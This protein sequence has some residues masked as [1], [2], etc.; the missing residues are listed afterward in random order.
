MEGAHSISIQFTPTGSSQALNCLPLQNFTISSPS[1]LFDGMPNAYVEI[2]L[3]C[4]CLVIQLQHEF[5]MCPMNFV[6][7]LGIIFNSHICQWL[8]VITAEYMVNTYLMLLPILYWSLWIVNYKP[9]SKFLNDISFKLSYH[10]FNNFSVTG[11]SFAVEATYNG[12]N[13]ILAIDSPSEG[14]FCCQLDI[15]TC[16]NCESSNSTLLALFV[17]IIKA[18]EVHYY[19]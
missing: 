16:I 4:K 1:K 19:V 2:L 5:S 12:S 8:Y 15:G 18:I 17:A 3:Q 10:M 6:N 14:M 9:G 13:I 7:K 11:F